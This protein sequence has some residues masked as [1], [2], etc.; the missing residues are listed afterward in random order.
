MGA[1]MTQIHL[2]EDI[3]DTQ[4]KA[5]KKPISESYPFALASDSL[6]SCIGVFPPQS[7]A[8]Q[9]S[10]IL[11]PT[12]ET[13]TDTF[14]LTRQIKSYV[15]FRNV[16]RYDFE[17]NQWTYQ[18]GDIAAQA[19]G[20]VSVTWSYRVNTRAS[21]S[22]NTQVS[23]IPE[24][25]AIE[26]R[27][28]P[29]ADPGIIQQTI[30]FSNRYFTAANNPI[31]LTMAVELSLS[32]AITSVKTWGLYSVSSGYFFRMKGSGLVDNFLVGYRQTLGGTTTD[33]EIPRSAFNG[34]KL[35]GISNSVHA[36]TFTNVAMFGI[37]VGT[38]GI[39]ARF[40]AYVNVG[41][42]ARWVLVHSLY[43]DSDSSQ[44]RITDE[45]AWPICFE[46]IN[47]GIS[48]TTQTLAKY[49]VSVTSIGSPVGT[50]NVSF[51]SSNTTLSLITS[52][53]PILGIKAKEFVNSKQNSNTILPVSLSAIASTGIW[54][55]TLI[56]NPTKPTN[57]VLS[58]SSVSSVIE[59]SSQNFSIQSGI[60]LGSYLLA[61]NKAINIDL[62][63][64]FAL[65]KSFLTTQYTNDPV[66]SG[67]Y[68]QQF[69]KNADEI[70]ICISRV[71]SA[72]FTNEVVWSSSS[73]NTTATYTDTLSSGLSINATISVS[74]GVQEV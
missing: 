20:S 69:V 16:S 7:D 71:I 46:N 35:D 59:S 53:L 52:S 73:V 36:Q 15:L 6:I 31:V 38:A 27:N 5:G 14:S 3:A 70:W 9:I 65:N 28:Y 32:D 4:S 45:E 64:L 72:N 50:S 48:T 47:Y 10:P 13:I 11:K 33:I 24:Q 37:E 58:F 12:S 74:L 26:L 29:N 62:K 56:K 43:S 8:E 1:T 60:I 55:I 30:L 34:D 42:S 19:I 68:G 2:P 66:P 22:S 54:R 51:V 67:D 61:A 17:P 40:W 39:G 23:F 21:Y 41:N 49:G 44:N 63:D 25:S 57:P 18:T